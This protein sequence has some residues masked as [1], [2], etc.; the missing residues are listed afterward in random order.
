MSIK[1]REKMSKERPF[2]AVLLVILQVLGALGFLGL[3]GF[4]LGGTGLFAS[5]QGIPGL[6]FLAGMT[7]LFLY[8]GAFL[9]SLGIISLIIA[10]G[11]WTGQGWAWIL[12]LVLTIISIILSIPAAIGGVGIVGIIID[13]IILYCITRSDVMEFLRP[14]IWL[15]EFRVRMQP[16]IREIKFTLGKVKGNPLSIIGLSL[17]LFFVALALLAPFIARPGDPTQGGDPFLIPHEGY[18]Y[19]PKPP[20][21][22]HLFGTMSGQ[23]DIFYGC[24]WGTITSFRIGL[25]TVGI[26]LIIGL[27]LGVFAG[28]FGGI[29]DEILMRFTDIIFAFPTLILAMAL[30]VVLV[31]MG[32]NRLDAIVISIVV[33][34]W[35]GYAR[36]IRGEVLRVKNEDYIEAAKSIGCSDLRVIIK[37]ILPNAIYPIVIMATLDIGTIVILAAALSF[38]GLGAPWGYADWGWMISQARNFIYSNPTNPY[39][40]WYAFIIPGVFISLF[41]LGW[42]L[43]GDAFRDILDPTVRRR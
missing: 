23:Y 20:N 4:L 25:V 10:W 7:G 34:G 19:Y 8:V 6:E 31:P 17:I 29:T 28:Y 1:M 21:S 43:L 3:G 5:L 13:M 41:V 42:N 24:I 38:L 9:L 33:I 35:P 18:E 14:R 36:V 22:K 39:V 15:Q 40:Y 16:Q 27:S 37:H 32:I 12:S 30:I 2:G 26:S 11:L